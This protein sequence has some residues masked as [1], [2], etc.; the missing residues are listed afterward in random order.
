MTIA[1]SRPGLSGLSGRLLLVGLLFLPTALMLVASLRGPEPIR[2]MLWIGVGLEATLCGMLLCNP[3]SLRDTLGPPVY[4]LYLAGL[5]WLW[6]GTRGSADWFSYLAQA[7]LLIFLVLAYGLHV[8]N[9]SGAVALRRARVL[10]DRL[11]ARKDLPTDPVLCRVLP[12]VRAFRESLQL[13]TSPALGLLNHPRLAVRVAALCALEFRQNWHPGQAEMVLQFAR[14]AQEPEARAAALAALVY[15]DGQ[16]L[17]EGLA[18]FLRDPV[19]DV[20][21]VASE[22]LLWDT[23]HRWR[24][25]RTAIRHALGDPALQN[26]GP[27]QCTGQPLS[28]EMIADLTAWSAEKGLLGLRASLTLAAYYGRMLRE[29]PDDKL[30]NELRERLASPHTPPTLRVELARLL[31]ANRELDRPLLEKLIAPANPAPL[32]LLAVEALLAER[33]HPDAPTVLRDLAH[34]PNREIA[35]ATAVVV[36][37]RLGYDLGLDLNEPLP[38]LHSRQAAD[39]TRRVMKWAAIQL[40]QAQEADR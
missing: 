20:R 34:L 17:V 26:D 37:Q 24:W 30:V 1:I 40:E 5:A 4:L 3:R 39:I 29:R 21:R 8:L 33:D 38:A 14:R 23:E 11:S 32:R 35:L 9:S 36:Q 31:Q 25:M 27:L 16:L 28:S 18:E 6:L 7:L 22:T 2:L 12:E 13:D 15:L 19:P 10:A